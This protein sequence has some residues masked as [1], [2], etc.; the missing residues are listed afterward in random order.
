[1]PEI[2]P[3][4]TTL[5]DKCPTCGKVKKEKT[6]FEFNGTKFSYLECG[7]LI[8]TV[9][10]KQ[11]PYETIVSNSWIDEVKNCQHE[12]NKNTCVRC[13]E[14]RMFSY[15]IDSARAIE[16][17]LGRFGL[18]H[19]QGLGKTIIGLAWL[20]FHPEAL[21]YLIVCKSSL[22]FQF[23]KEIV[24]WISPLYAPQIIETAKD[25]LLPMFKGYIVSYDLLRRFDLQ[26]FYDVGI[27]SLILDECQQIKNPDSART[28]EVR[29]LVKEC[30]EYVIPMSGTPWKNRGSEF[31]VALNILAPEKFYSFAAFKSQWVDYYWNGAKYKEGGIRRID[32]FRKLTSDILIRK[33]RVEVMPELPLIDRH[34]Q[35]VE[36]DKYG[37]EE[38]E[39][40]LNDF[41]RIY[42]QAVISGEE[43]S[44]KEGGNILA[45][46]AKMRH[47]T[48]RAKIPATIEFVQEF[49]DQTDRKIVV[50]V[51]HKD[52]GDAIFKVLVE[53]CKLQNNGM[54]APL[55]ITGEM[56]SEERFHTQ[57]KFNDAHRILIASTLAAGEGLNL[58]SC[59]DCIVHERQWNPANEEQ[60]EGR[61]IRIGQTADSVTA[62]YM[63]AEG[64]VDNILADI[65]N[66]KRVAF[67]AVMSNEGITWN[68]SD[69]IKRLSEG[70][71]KQR[72]NK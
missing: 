39:I 45:A 40:Y 29:R 14:H 46:L 57:E 67:N 23:F 54:L 69:I 63:T 27:K 61:F 30:G 66:E 17:N 12:W 56:D 11:N 24:R 43:D 36:M 37:K 71:I 38:Y 55:K 51:H 70:I 16:H 35:Y 19:E 52:V 18:F 5:H 34:L 6:S 2:P 26:K 3:R 50:F 7:H 1:M 32:D 65:V 20:K 8:T 25:E 60:A 48:G 72:Q 62:T 21:K 58:Q 33:E 42:N 28:Q 13:S 68:Q 44:F 4:I 49:I 10:P 22:K 15:Q 41:I 53:W 59:S 47:A 64:T 31:F 9:L